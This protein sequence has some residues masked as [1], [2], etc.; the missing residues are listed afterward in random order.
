MPLYLHVYPIFSPFTPVPSKIN[1]WLH[2]SLVDGSRSTLV[3]LLPR[4]ELRRGHGPDNHSSE[5]LDLLLSYNNG[6][7]LTL[8]VVERLELQTRYRDGET[9]TRLGRDWGR[10]RIQSE[11][12][13]GRRHPSKRVTR[14][15]K[16]GTQ[17][18]VDGAWR[19]EGL[20]SN[21]R[22]RS[23]SEKTLCHGFQ[24][25]KVNETQGDETK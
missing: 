16:D 19:V 7:P 8:P 11:R 12:K 21:L 3:T 17:E 24:G 4:P 14:L 6:R 1:T 20:K 22:C 10:R 9:H 18:Y 23:T 15:E 13:R 25:G 2:F 5:T